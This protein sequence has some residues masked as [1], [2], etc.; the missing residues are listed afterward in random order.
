VHYL[1][2]A[3]I[4]A[5]RVR[6]FSCFHPQGF[7]QASR[8]DSPFLICKLPRRLYTRISRCQEGHHYTLM[9]LGVSVCLTNDVL[10]LA[11]AAITAHLSRRFGCF[12]FGANSLCFSA[13]CTRGRAP[14][15]VGEVQG[16]SRHAGWV[17]WLIIVVAVTIGKVPPL[18]YS[19]VV[20]KTRGDPLHMNRVPQ[21]P[22]AASSFIGLGRCGLPAG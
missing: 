21:S 14:G 17:C 2:Q 7:R 20:T 6:G 18:W 15:C 9:A 8:F 1:A 3:A 4:T 5:L 13:A 10:Y 19:I 16:S 22:R 11:Q 12:P